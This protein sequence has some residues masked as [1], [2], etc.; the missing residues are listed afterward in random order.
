[1]N[2]LIPCI[3][4]EYEEWPRLSLT[5]AQ[6]ARL[7]NAEAHTSAAALRALVRVG[8]LAQRSDGRFVRR[9]EARHSGY[10]S[11]AA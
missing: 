10:R 4:R 5:L 6:A 2:R 7:W 1:M 9:E 3:R 11:L 8:F